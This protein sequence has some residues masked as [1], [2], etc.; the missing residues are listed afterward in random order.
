LFARF[1]T[2]CAAPTIIVALALAPAAVV[3]GC[4]DVEGGAIE[5]S[6]VLRTFDGRAISGCG[7]SNP[8]IARVR[9]V[10]RSTADEGEHLGDDVCAGRSGC[11]FS[12]RSQRGATPFFVPAGRYALSVLPLGTGGEVLT[13]APSGGGGVRVPAPILRAVEFGRPTQLDAVA[14]ESGCAQVCNGDLSNK[15]CSKD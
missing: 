5:A 7:C 6:W 11:E 4:V 10:V 12:C 14:I 3:G 8:E 15:V 1:K 9:F 2:A 13:G